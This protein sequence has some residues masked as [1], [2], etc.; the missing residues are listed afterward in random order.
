MVI[1]DEAGVHHLPV[2]SFTNQELDEMHFSY[3]DALKSLRTKLA[4]AQSE[5]AKLDLER[6]RLLEENFELHQKLNAAKTP[7]AAASEKS[8]ALPPTPSPA[9]A[10]IFP[11]PVSLDPLWKIPVEAS[12]REEYEKLGL[13]AKNQGRRGSCTIFGTLG[14]IEYHLAK[15]GEGVRLSEQFASWA[16][17]HV[18][19]KFGKLKAYD[20]EEVL[21]GIR[22][23]GITTEE[24][25]PYRINNVGHPSK[26]A[27][28]DAATR[29]NV[30][31][32]WFERLDDYKVGFSED[33]L[34]AI[35]GS[36]SEGSPVSVQ[37]VWPSDDH[38]DKKFVLE[39]PRLSPRRDKGH[40][41]VL[42]GYEKTDKYPGGGLF[43]FR[44]S[45]GADY[46][47]QGYAKFTFDYLIKYGFGAYSI[48]LY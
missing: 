43:T 15:R 40:V 24:L 2:E 1:S 16:A 31:I 22:E 46:G 38:L 7:P 3:R 35:C 13:T 8:S 34:R 9:A 33:V 17:D 29:R 5:I 20:P 39:T 47:D 12:L 23:Y 48:R 11:P 30:A 28:A 27:V 25:M 45:W 36:I 19:K 18:T 4:G 41:V 44:Q 6:H 42:I 26:E 21:D 14:V 10:T 32:T 37:C